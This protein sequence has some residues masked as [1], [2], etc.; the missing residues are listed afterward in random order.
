M[1]ELKETKTKQE[2]IHEKG[3]DL[4]NFGMPV[5]DENGVINYNKIKVGVKQLEDALLD[6]GTLK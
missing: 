5:I 2:A 3:F 1:N 4:F 6:L